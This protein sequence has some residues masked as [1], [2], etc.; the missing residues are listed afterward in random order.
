MNSS[1]IS[2]DMGQVHDTTPSAGPEQDHV[3]EI[4]T[5]T[6]VIVEPVIAELVTTEPDSPYRA[7]CEAAIQYVKAHS[8]KPTTRAISTEVATQVE[9]VL[10]GVNLSS[11]E[12]TA[13]WRALMA[14]VYALESLDN[15]SAALH[16]AEALI[17]NK[18]TM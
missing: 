5:A 12:Q 16:H 18:S 8:D 2:S 3:K 15:A 6:L 10:R 9:Q 1:E 7:R 17:Q 4:R 14:A 13:T 11:I